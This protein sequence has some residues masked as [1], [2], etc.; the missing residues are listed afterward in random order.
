MAVTIAPDGSFRER[1]LSHG[2]PPLAIGAVENPP[3]NFFS[4]LGNYKD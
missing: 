1:R 3:F 2:L 4:G